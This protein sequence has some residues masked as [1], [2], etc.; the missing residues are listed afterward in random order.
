MTRYGVDKAL[1]RVV[2][3]EGPRDAFRKDPEPFL[4][5]CRD[6][7]E[8][9]TH[10]F[11]HANYFPDLT[12]DEQPVGML[13]WESL[14]DMTPGPHDLGGGAGG[15]SFP[16]VPASGERPYEAILSCSRPMPASAWPI[17]AEKIGPAMRSAPKREISAGGTRP[18]FHPITGRFQAAMAAS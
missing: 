16:R 14:R 8:T 15:F 7:H 12:M 2:L 18:T 10:I 5:G 11:V 13:R 6:F 17:R 3:D 1:R 9:E 4:E